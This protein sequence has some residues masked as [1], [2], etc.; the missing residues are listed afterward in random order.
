MKSRLL[1]P[2]RFRLIGWL[3]AL[4]GFVLGYLVVYNDYKIPGF[5]FVLR[6]KSTLFLPAS[7][8][9]TNELALTMVITGL[10]FIAFSKQKV[11]DEL[12]A[13]MRLNALYWAIL[14][15]F[16]WYGVLV[17]FAVIN[18]I[19]HISGIENIVEFA[20]N[21]LT[22]TVY[23]L[24][25]PLVILVARF[26]Y[27]LYKKKEE[28]Q[29][30]PLR[31]LPNKPYRA[32]GVI[33]SAG[34]FAG[35]IMASL[36]GVDENKLAVSYLLPL[37]MLLWVYSKEKQEDEYINL[38]RLNAMQI[39]VFVNYAIL[40]VGNFLVYGLAFLYVLVFNLATIPTIFLIVFHYRLYRIRQANNDR[41]NLNVT[42]L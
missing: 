33:L 34:L 29:I 10:L 40:L 8:N 15:N 25:M 22:F 12:T 20:A 18:T 17:V 31:F 42:L 37:V 41:S 38:I 23:N 32:L 14:V 7:E 28:Y 30:K 1:F 36:I 11:E 16:C 27:L 4:P 19:I 39:A 26:Y 21:N 13:T 5:E 3:L 6:G 35:L 24:F 2:N 9:F